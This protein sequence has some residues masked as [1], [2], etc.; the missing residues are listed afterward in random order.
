[1]P[2]NQ[3]DLHLTLSEM[4]W[5]LNFLRLMI[6][7]NFYVLCCL[8]RCDVTP[9]H[10]VGTISF[11]VEEFGIWS[12]DFPVIDMFLYSHHLSLW[13]CVVI[14]RRNTVLVTLGS[15]N[16]KHC[17]SLHKVSHNAVIIS[18]LELFQQ[19]FFK[20]DENLKM[21]FNQFVSVSQGVKNEIDKWIFG[22]E[23]ATIL[24]KKRRTTFMLHSWVLC[25]FPI[26]CLKKYLFE[27]I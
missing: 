14:I 3:F 9:L 25:P 24:L 27:C 6:G 26:L 20:F 18:S 2:S 1:M 5:S 15:L 10:I 17:V 4:S 23:Y 12:M 7:N 21:V 16:V 22:F 19:L 13:Y 8:G 11:E